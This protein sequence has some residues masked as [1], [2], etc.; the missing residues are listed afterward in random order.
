MCGR[1]AMQETNEEIIERFEVEES[2]FVSPPRYNIAPSQIVAIILDNGTRYMAGLKWGLV[3]SWSKDI[4]IGNKLINARAETLSE[5]PSFRNA[6]KRQRCIIPASGFF[7]WKKEGD[8]RIPTYIRLKNQKL[9]AMAGLWEKWQNSDG[10]I[11][12]T[13]TIITVS[14]NRFMES[15]HNRMPAILK[16]EEESI[17]LDPSIQNKNDL[18]QLLQPYADED[19]EAYAVSKRVNSPTNDDMDCIKPV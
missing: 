14:P 15:I 9:F 1:F 11:L 13:F 19:M 3:P 12:Q 8:Q 7:E 6:F 17:W 10:S 5:K 18:H 2:L 16:P 4:K